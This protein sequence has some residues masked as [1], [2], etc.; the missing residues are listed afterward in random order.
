MD[1][2]CP[3]RF[4]R[5]GIV[6]PVLAGDEF[7]V[8]VIE[9][10]LLCFPADDAVTLVGLN[11]EFTFSA[12]VP[13]VSGYGTDPSTASGDFHHDFG[14]P[15]DSALDLLDLAGSKSAAGASAA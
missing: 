4:L 13:E 11:G 12:D 8:P 2:L 6:R 1:Q 3:S 15:S 14:D 9:Q 7:Q 5:L 10:H